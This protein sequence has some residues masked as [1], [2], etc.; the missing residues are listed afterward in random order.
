MVLMMRCKS[1]MKVRVC[2]YSASIVA[3]R[4]GSDMSTFQGRIASASKRQRPVSAHA[5]T[6]QRQVPRCV[7]FAE[8][9]RTSAGK[10]QKF[11]LRQMAKAA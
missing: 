4:S 1:F 9:P 6:P 2:K 7:V 10:V 11:K 3:S 5:D 8:I